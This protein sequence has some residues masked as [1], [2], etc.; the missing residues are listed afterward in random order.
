MHVYGCN[1][2]ALPTNIHSKICALLV[3][4]SKKDDG[5]VCYV[6]T[7]TGEVCI[8][9]SR[10]LARAGHEVS[11]MLIAQTTYEKPDGIILTGNTSGLVGNLDDWVRVAWCGPNFGSKYSP[12]KF[13]TKPYQVT[14]T[15][16]FLQT[17]MYTL[18][19]WLKSMW[20]TCLLS[21]PTSH[22][23]LTYVD[24]FIAF[25]TRCSFPMTPQV[26]LRCARTNAR[27]C[28]LFLIRI[29]N[30]LQLTRSYFFNRLEHMCNSLV[31][32]T[33]CPKKFTS[34]PRQGTEEGNFLCRQ[35]KK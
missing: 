17:P 11:S 4:A 21:I 35:F 6:N 19:C 28:F 34:A 8:L 26:H 3:L 20:R 1:Y 29:V 18:T 14:T 12:K 2:K 25:R 15:R 22:H 16:G 32:C 5:K 31:T 9:H 30:F 24:D 13:N 23:T 7:E 33:S 10:L 27:F